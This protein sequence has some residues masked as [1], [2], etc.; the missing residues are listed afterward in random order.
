MDSM[1]TFSVPGMPKYSRNLVSGER[2]GRQPAIANRTKNGTAPLTQVT[3]GDRPPPQGAREFSSLQAR[4]GAFARARTYRTRHVRSPR[5]PCT[6]N[7]PT[8]AA[9]AK[10]P[11]RALI[12]LDLLAVIDAAHFF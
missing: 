1:S 2:A 4:G 10:A 6:G 7:G 11:P 3:C 8:L 5:R 12:T 9:R